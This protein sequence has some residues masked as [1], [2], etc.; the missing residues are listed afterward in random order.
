M[1]CEIRFHGR[2]GQGVV[3][4][5][6]LLVEAAFYEGLW[7]QAI[8][9]FGAERRGAPVVAYARISDKPIR[10][11]SQVYSPDIVVV[12]DERLVK[13]VNVHQGLK[14]NGIL[15]VNAEEVLDEMKPPKHGKVKLAITPATR[16]ALD[17]NLI[18]AGW[19]VINTAMLG[20]FSKATGLVGIDSVEKA[21]K[22][23][24]PGK[25]GELNAKAARLAYEKTIFIGE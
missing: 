6:Q 22:N 13:I 2:G 10:I 16:I 25:I 19:P 23:N 15:I 24:W 12:F 18:V 7:G 8:P 14:D 1:L 11:H 21:I 5:A 3:T 20:A 9:F 17:L 4:A